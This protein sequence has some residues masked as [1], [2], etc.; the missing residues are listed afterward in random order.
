MRRSIFRKTLVICAFCALSGCAT[1]GGMLPSMISPKATLGVDT[2]TRGTLLN[3]PQPSAKTTIAV[4]QFA[5]Q[6][7]QFKQSGSENQSLSRAL[8]QGADSIV[9]QA[10]RDA[11]NGTWFNV[12]ERSGLTDLLQERQLIRSMRREYLGEE[13][14]DPANLPPLVFAGAIIRGG[15]IGYDSNVVTGG[16]GARFLG[17][18]G[19][20][21]YREN[22]ITVA[23]RLVS[24][25]N[26][27]VVASVTARKTVLSVSI[28]GGLT[29]FVSFKRLLEAESGVTANEPA[30]VALQQA[31]EHGVMALIVQASRRGVW[32]FADQQAGEEILAAFEQENNIA[33]ILPE[34]TELQVDDRQILNTQP[35]NGPP[36][37]PQPDPNQPARSIEGCRR[38]ICPELEKDGG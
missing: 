18:G 1:N 9:I 11:G 35:N 4:Y 31:I 24:V 3:L 17:I 33:S 28:Q 22:V 25:K 21:Q 29:R 26:G 10:L 30:L 23:L 37:Q 32:K 12:V 5:D 20:T 8:T 38:T 36:P 2:E 34:G 19:S 13:R 14:V 7:G 27:E 6:T 15:I 16:M